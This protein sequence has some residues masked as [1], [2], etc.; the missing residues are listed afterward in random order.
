MK[1][2]KSFVGNERGM[3]I[4]F[5][6][7]AMIALLGFLGLGVDVGYTYIAK[8][9]LQNAADA[10]ALAG[11]ATLYQ[12]FS[13]NLNWVS[14]QQ[15]AT[16]FAQTNIAT[17]MQLT[18]A[19]AMTGYWTP[20]GMQPTSYVPTAADVPAVWVTVSKSAGSNGGPVPTFFAQY[21]GW[22]SFSI[23]AN[24]VA[25][26]KV[27]GTMTGGIF[28]VAIL[29]SFAVANPVSQ[30]SGASSPI[31]LRPDD[32]T[33]SMWTTLNEGTGAT[34]LSNLTNP[35]YLL[36][37][38][39]SIGDQIQSSAGANDT[40]FTNINNCSGTVVFF[41]VLA[42]FASNKIA[43]FIPFLITSAT[44]GAAQTIQGFFEA[45]V[46]T[47]FGGSAGVAGGNYGTYAAVLVH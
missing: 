28:P 31:T 22:S 7:I 47:R 4:I 34:V 6:L 13:P 14:A 19:E 25:A 9:E 39:L 42:D 35:N 36:N 5:I 2:K 38:P 24:A 41:P 16:L 1:G 17:G 33:L 20:S 40:I 18:D 44:G 3:A 26:V 10:G 43:G 37:V 23:S 12:G 11:A 29:Q 27:V 21:L 46:I 8:G 45:P 32:G 30:G 15:Q